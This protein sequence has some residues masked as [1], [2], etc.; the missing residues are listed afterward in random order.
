MTDAELSRDLALAIGWKHVYIEH[1]VCRVGEPLMPGRGVDHI[2]NW[3]AFNYFAPDV[4]LPLLDM[5][6]REHKCIIEPSVL[7]GDIGVWIKDFGYTWAD[8]LPEAVA[9]AVI[10]VK[11]AG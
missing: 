10:A 9:K 5:L 7:N 11:G 3:K 6:M 8:T 2:L 4:C 1:G